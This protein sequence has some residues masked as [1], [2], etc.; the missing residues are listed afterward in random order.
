MPVKPKGVWGIDIGQCALKA[1]RLEHDRRRSRPPPPS[2]TSSTP[3]SSA[4]PTPTRTSSPAR[5]WRSSSRATTL[6]GDD[7]RHQRPRPER[8]GPVRQAAAGRGEEDRRHRQVRGQAADPLPARRSRLGL[9]EDRPAATVDRRLR[10]GD[11][12]RPVRHEARHDQPL[13]AALQGRRTSR[14]T[15]SRWRRS[16]CATSSPS[17]CSKQGRPDA[18]RG[19][20]EDDAARQEAVRRRPRHRHRQLAT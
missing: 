16:P 17:T 3:R 20:E 14:S 7:G 19:G 15:S 2:T 1:L 6:K 18:R 13:P 4:S 11:R 5:R 10:H 9:P 12:D 8:P